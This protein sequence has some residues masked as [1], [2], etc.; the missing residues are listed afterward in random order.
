MKK[1]CFDTS[2]LTNPLQHM[3]QD[4][5]EGMWKQIRDFI[6]SGQIAV[7]AEVYEELSR[8]PGAIG[9][10]IRNNKKRLLLEVDDDAWDW[11]AYIVH[12]S[13]LITTYQSFISEYNNN[14]KGTVG[15]NDI[16][17]IAL[18]KTLNIAVVSME[19]PVLVPGNQSKAKRRIPDICV[20]ERI[21]HLTFNDFLRRERILS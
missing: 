8:I 21:V 13:S 19:V 1:Y 16:S 6:E 10:C 20:A 11:K 7:T 2:G 14:I 4:L 5:H 9:D 3:P 12:S 18:A 17:I 15:M